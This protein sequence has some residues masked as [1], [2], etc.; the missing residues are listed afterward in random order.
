[1]AE[2]ALKQDAGAFLQLLFK[3]NSYTCEQVLVV[4]SSAQL[5]GCT[6]ASQV[7]QG[8]PAL[9]P[10]TQVH[11][12]RL[13]PE[14]VLY[15]LFLALRRESQSQACCKWEQLSWHQWDYNH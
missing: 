7:C 1:M 5:L 15:E 2:L 9:G 10:S 6:K 4:V 3:K 8:C 13:P 11:F 12:A 14:P